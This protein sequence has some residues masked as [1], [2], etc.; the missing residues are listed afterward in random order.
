VEHG[1]AGHGSHGGRAGHAWSHLEAEQRQRL[2]VVDAWWTLLGRPVGKRVADIGCGPGLFAARL[3]E[4]GADVLAVDV[5]ADALASV[6]RRPRLRTLLHDLESG[7]LP[8][9]VDAAVLA[10]VLHHVRDPAAL[11]RNL[12]GSAPVVLVAETL[13]G[14][15]KARAPRLALD[16][17]SALLKEAG[18]SPGAAVWPTPDQA[19][20][21]GRAG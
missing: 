12:R 4:L 21:L 15:G 11:L 19:V 7:P 13:A 1:D 6:P 8:E 20:V 5:R 17:V 2:P 14:P 18:Y 3:A 10:D 9:R 16:R